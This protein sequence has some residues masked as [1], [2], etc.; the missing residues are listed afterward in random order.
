MPPKEPKLMRLFRRMR[1]A[2][3][4]S[5]TCPCFPSGNAQPYQSP[6]G[7]AARTGMRVLTTIGLETA[8]TFG[9]IA[10]NVNP[11]GIEASRARALAEG[12]RAD[13]DA[14]LEHRIG[15]TRIGSLPWTAIITRG[16][17]VRVLA[18]CAT[19]TS[20]PSNFAHGCSL[21]ALPDDGADPRAIKGGES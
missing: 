6:Q 11:L 20:T 2:N 9:T 4:W 10:T 12:R 5:L 15:T 21:L 18:S 3:Q 8:N 1:S 19:G 7:S 14:A 13:P 16:I 17:T